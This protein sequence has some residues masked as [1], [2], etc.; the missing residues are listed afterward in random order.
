MPRCLLR[1][2]WVG[3]LACLLGVTSTLW[4]AGAQAQAIATPETTAP[5]APDAAAW[6][7]LYADDLR[8]SADADAWALGD[9]TT[10]DPGQGLTN[11]T[12]KLQAKFKQTV[13]APAVRLSYDARMLAAGDMD[14]IGDLSC[15]L[16]PVVFHVGGNN[17]TWTGIA[18]PP[19]SGRRAAWR[20]ELNR[21]YHV[22]A[23]IDGDVCRLWVD[24]VLLATERL[25]QPFTTGNVQLFCTRGTACFTNVRLLVGDRARDAAPTAAVLSPPTYQA[26]DPQRTLLLTWAEDPVTSMD[27][28]WLQRADELPA[29]FTWRAA[30]TDAAWQPAP[31]GRTPF[32]HSNLQRCRV[33]LRNLAPDTRYEFRLTTP[34]MNDQPMAPVRF[35]TAPG[36]LRDSLRF[37]T[38]GDADVTDECIQ[39]SRQ[40]AARDPL[41]AVLG[42]DIAYANGKDS[43]RW[44]AFLD[45]WSTHMRAPGNRAIPL[46]CAMGNHEVAGGFDQQLAAA[47]FMTTLFPL[48]EARAYHVLDFGNYL[49]LIILDSGHVTPVAGTQ[50]DW[51]KQTLVQRR[52]VPHRFAFYHVPA[53]PSVRK[54]T[55]ERSV[56][57]RQHWPPLFEQFRLNAAFENHDH[58]YKRTHPLRAGQPDPAGVLYLGDGAWGV[59]H[60]PPRPADS[61]NY[62]ARTQRAH[63]F[64]ETVITPA[65]RTFTVI[66]PQ[67]Q[68]IDQVTQNN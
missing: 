17:N 4:V 12:G 33:T 48:L 2:W 45:I 25:A 6:R 59:A 19:Y 42:G 27:V 55:D 30:D 51:L 20:L 10:I 40:A 61:T 66:D 23:Q 1:L 62:L 53:W 44:L 24:G 57:V 56:A 37:V 47:P 22:I 35:R 60:R 65:G 39:I 63:H 9:G 16:G 15:I 34:A 26:V 13:H 43:G 21:S 8:S 7:P 49:S 14:R 50:T 32:P 46:L 29:D 38:G 18:Q 11:P 31:A 67:G 52:A 36:L 68:I 28:Q 58:A 3:M 5:A 41:F 54:F 64:I